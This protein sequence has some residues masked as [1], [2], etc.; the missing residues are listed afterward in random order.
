MATLSE[1]W[2]EQRQTTKIDSGTTFCCLND[3]NENIIIPT[4]GM[5]SI[6]LPGVTGMT[7]GGGLIDINTPTATN[8]FKVGNV[9]GM[10]VGDFYIDMSKQDSI[11]LNSTVDSIKQFKVGNVTGMTVGDFVNINDY[12]ETDKTYGIRLGNEG[13]KFTTNVQNI[14]IGKNSMRGYS[15]GSYTWG[16]LKNIAIGENTLKSI[17]DGNN[18]IVI[19]TNAMQDGFDSTNN[20]A[21]G[22]NTLGLSQTNDTNIAIGDYSM[23]NAVDDCNYNVGVGY[24]SLS[25]LVSG[26]T[27]VAVGLNALSLLENGNNNTAIGASTDVVSG[28]TSNAICIG[29][30]AKA[31]SSNEISIGNS[32]NTKLKIGNDIV[33]LNIPT[34]SPTFSGKFG[35]YTFDST[36][37]TESQKLGSLLEI[38]TAQSGDNCEIGINGSLLN[39]T[40]T[41][42]NATNIN[43]NET[44]AN[45]TIILGNSSVAHIRCQQQTIE[46][47]SDIRDKK[48][49]KPIK[50]GIEFINEL[51]PV[52]FTWNMRD[53]GMVDVKAMGFIAQQLQ[54]VQEK[55]NIEV[56]GLVVQ[57]EEDK[58]GAAYAALLPLMVKSIQDLSKEIENLKEEI[59]VLKNK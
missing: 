59:K 32:E 28:N 18:N 24:A 50:R 39:I 2:S 23:S 41:P 58:L 4:S 44:P 17:K 37:Q 45:N 31:S 47:L 22:E 35:S 40:N 19:G 7:I 42:T 52:E 51:T 36:P 8:Q 5:T 3:L 27:N 12:I 34:G 30:N 49:I 1:K 57:F 16:G 54:E 26:N 55:T 56:P 33:T 53:G 9:T 46:G 15:G 21:I 14:A 10:T 25:A 48:D 11:G 6:S 13:G 38:N 20:I 43:T 29:Y